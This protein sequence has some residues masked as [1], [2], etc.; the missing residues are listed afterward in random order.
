[1]TKEEKKIAAGV[2]TLQS[3]L[4]VNDPDFEAAQLVYRAI[5]HPLR[6][7]I[8]KL[9]D[10]GKDVTVSQIYRALEIEQ[11]IA[12]NQLRILKDAG[13]VFPKVDGRFVYYKINNEFINTLKEVSILITNKNSK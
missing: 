9:I 2:I 7:Q 11:S 8:L 3:G 12:S 1:M 10:S 6:Q 13:L 5:N 4:V